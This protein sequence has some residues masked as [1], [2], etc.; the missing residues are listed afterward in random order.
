MK[1]DNLTRRLLSAICVGVLSC[2]S[3]CQ[4]GPADRDLSSYHGQVFINE[5]MAANSRTIAD[6]AGDYDDWVEIYNARAEPMRLKGWYLTDDLAVTTKW[7]FPDTVIPAGSY[8]L[9][10]ADGECREGPLHASFKLKA[11]PGEQIGLYATE[12][13][14]ILIVDTLSFGPQGKD[15]SYGRIPDGSSHWQFLTIPTPGARNVTDGSEYRGVLFINEF[16]AANSSTIADEAGDYDD[17]IE[18]YNASSDALELSG[19]YLTDNLAVPNKWVLPDTTVPAR[20]FL[21]IW[22]DDEAEEGPL[23]A[24]F[25]LAAAVGEQI[26]IYSSYGGR[27]RIVDTLS[28]GPQHRDTSYGRLPDGSAGWQFMPNPTPGRT[29]RSR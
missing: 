3:G 10:W 18:L 25:N 4:A 15:T 8:L 5:F 29:N 12:Y 26:G 6:E 20:G 16:M 13:D 28:F 21:L 7:A 11:S 2:L 17:W 22:A 27:V 14:N 9:V 19:I 1:G 23:H 24:N